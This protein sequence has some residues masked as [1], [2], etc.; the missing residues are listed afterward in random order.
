MSET[1]NIGVCACSLGEKV[2]NN[3]RHSLDTYLTETLAKYV[4]FIPACPE[5]ACGM[6]IP[7]ERLQQVDCGGEIRLIAA[8]SG[9][10]WTDRMIKCNHKLLDSLGEENIDGYILRREAVSCALDK[11]KIQ[12]TDGKQPRLAPGFFTRQMMERY[13]LLPLVDNLRLQ[14]PIIRENFIRRVFVY[15]R[16]RALLDKGMQIGRLV[17]FHTRH[18]ML[19]RGHDL[20]GYRQLGKLLGESSIF[21]TDEIFDTYGEMLFKSLSLTA[22]PRKN[23]D[24]LMH[25]MGYFKKDID[26]SDKSDLLNMI[27]AYKS[28]KTP[29]LV[30]MTIINHYARKLGKAYLQQ[31]YFLNPNP[32]ELKMLYHT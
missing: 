1:I 27:N 3:G 6:N 8:Q 7:R 29:L 4:K 16:W 31:Q 30:P 24:V 18:K 2:R 20:K 13:P 26:G 5:V 28:G 10:D 14:N 19:I 12:Q 17:D 11:S 9:E 22:T 23:A 21:N 25:A 32:A 15:K